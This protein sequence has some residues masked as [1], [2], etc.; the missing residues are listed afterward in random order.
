MEGEPRHFGHDH[1]LA[2]AALS[3]LILAILSLSFLQFQKSV[4]APFE[5]SGPRYKSLA[6]RE[7]EAVE[8]QRKT[9]TDSDGLS[10]YDELYLYRTS[11]YL[12]DTDSDG[13][14]DGAEANSG[15]DP[16]C[17]R[18]QNCGAP[19]EAANTQKV[20]PGIPQSMSPGFIGSPEQ[21]LGGFDPE[22]IRSLLRGAGVSDE[23]LSKVDDA[24]LKRLYE[25]VLGQTASSTVTSTTR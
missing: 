22:N 16:N 6:E 20:S 23:M 3:V 10:D 2:L 4:R 12:E 15:E 5:R 21:I 25:E 18:D 9:D 1:R 13:I 7:S 17:P 24:T 14:N 11:P 19:F 8:A